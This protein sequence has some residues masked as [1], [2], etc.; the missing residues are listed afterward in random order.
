MTDE[1][2]GLD[3]EAAAHAFERF[4]RGPGASGEG[5][6]LGL[7]IVRAIAERHGGSVEVH[8]ATFTLDLPP[9]RDI[10]GSTARTRA[11]TDV[12]GSR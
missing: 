3:D 5:S 4:W 11:D 1:G 7:A 9:L 12:E 6:G 2:P 10:S 8:G